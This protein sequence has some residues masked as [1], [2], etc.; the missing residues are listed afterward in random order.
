MYGRAQASV[1]T[2]GSITLADIAA[3]AGD[4]RDLVNRRLAE[5]VAGSSTAPANLQRAIGHALL[6]PGKRVRPILTL[7]TAAELGARDLAPALDAGCAVEL[8]HTA[9]LVLDDLPCMDD[10]STRRGLP[11]THTLFGEATATLGA[12]AM[13]SRAFGLV[14]AVEGIDAASRVE[15]VAILSKAAGAE[16]LVAGQE[17]DLNERSPTDP[18]A[19]ITSI[20]DQKTGALFVAAALMGG[21]IAGADAATLA[22]LDTFGRQ[23]G[24]AF[25]AFD[26]VI[27]ASRSSGEAGKDTGKD[28]G[29]ATVASLLGV[30]AAKAE[31]RR[32]VAGAVAT[33][34]P[35]AAANGP[36]ERFVTALFDSACR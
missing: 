4:A 11:T 3:H 35:F 1:T 28:S 14:A 13:L 9:S 24:L 6:A 23:I 32:H 34:A 10:A 12:I 33:I 29:K 30:D 17:R 2:T 21:R 5:I 16:G 31:V 15:L 18:I 7:L 36:M 8:V 22:L 27:D 19:T 26:D 25:Q 20:N